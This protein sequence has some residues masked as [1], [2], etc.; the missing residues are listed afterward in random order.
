[1]QSLSQFETQ[2]IWWGLCLLVRTAPVVVFIVCI[3]QPADDA[4]LSVYGLRVQQHHAQSSVTP[5]LYPDPSIELW[6]RALAPTSLATYI[7]V[8]YFQLGTHAAL[9]TTFGYLSVL[10]VLDISLQLAAAFY[11][12]QANVQ[13]STVVFCSVLSAG[14][15]LI[16]VG[17]LWAHVALQNRKTVDTMKGAKVQLMFG[18]AVECG[19]HVT[20]STASMIHAIHSE[21]NC[22]QT[23]L[24]E[25]CETV[26]VLG[27]CANVTCLLILLSESIHK[28]RKL[29]Q[30]L[31]G[32]SNRVV[33]MGKVLWRQFSLFP[34]AIVLLGVDRNATAGPRVAS[35]AGVTGTAI[36]IFGMVTALRHFLMPPTESAVSSTTV[37]D[38][39]LAKPQSVVY[40]P[41]TAIVRKPLHVKAL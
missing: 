37:E 2:W 18:F 1:M 32:V 12:D 41:V 40:R 34:T 8:L 35:V 15:L 4:V 24:E 28:V 13:S 16:A 31:S 38:M 22:Q 11:F 9:R 21:I 26:L 23:L 3:T 30:T 14:H 17:N 19:L 36:L 6:I 7:F 5:S 25:D 29:T 10:S 33:S 27:I 39:V 20:L